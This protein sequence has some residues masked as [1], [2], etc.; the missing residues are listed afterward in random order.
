MKRLSLLLLLGLAAACQRATYLVIELKSTT[1]T[2]VIASLAVEVTLEGVTTKLSK[3]L[4]APIE[5]APAPTSQDPTESL[6]V[7]FAPERKGEVMVDV[8]AS[9]VDGIPLARAGG[10][11]ELLPGRT[12]RLLIDF[13]P[14][15]HDG[16]KTGEETDVDCGGPLCDPCA[17]GQACL[18]GRDCVSGY[19]D[20]GSLVCVECPLDDHKQC[21]NLCVP[22]EHCCSV[23]ECLAPEHG[24]ATCPPDGTGLC[25][26]V[27]EPGYHP[28]AGAS[29][30]RCVA[31]AVAI[32]AGPDHTC[33]LTSQGGI[34]CWGNNHDGQLGD[35][36]TEMR[37]E[38]VEVVGLVQLAASIAAGNGHTCARLAGT[39]AVA[40]W[41]LNDLGQL[42]DGTTERRLTPTDVTALPTGVL[43]VVAGYQHTC[44]RADGNQVWCWG[45]NHYGQLGSSPTDTCAGYACSKVPVAVGGPT[46]GIQAVAAGADHTCALGAVDGDCPS[47]VLCWGGNYFGQ[48]GDGSTLQRATPLV[49]DS[50]GAAVA[51]AAG[52]GHTC[53]VLDAGGIDCWGRNGT[54]QLGAPTATTC[55]AFPCSMT[56]IEVQG[57]FAGA[58]VVGGGQ[59]FTCALTDAGG[60][61]CWGDNSYGQLG[62]GGGGA[63][64]FRMT[65]GQVVGLDAGVSS[66][67]IGA[68]HACALMVSGG[69]R[70]W[71]RNMEGELGDG[72]RSERQV[73]T[74]VVG[75]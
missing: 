66:V 6:F 1:A 49:V 19:C 62:D 68:Y 55:S 12:A 32:T 15:C 71:G 4:A 18:L 63:G 31:D 53:A 2:L 65:P 29:G 40:C 58:T 33:A 48:L 43:D 36:T 59:G 22:I 75:F 52:N 9:G 26:F 42:G 39:G 5:L 25:G 73:P 56:P 34:R 45:F 37:L 17:L 8:Q 27:C 38:P 13:N 35:G 16:I 28:G 23:E 47:C 57:L 46:V 41:G 74:D 67:A 30:D 11:V 60:V 24:T 44:V 20:P 64:V 10:K 69:I 54:G 3:S 21:G 70:C 51:L 14:S 72:T 50:L 61:A 7:E